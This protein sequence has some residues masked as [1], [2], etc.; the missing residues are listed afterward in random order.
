MLTPTIEDV[1]TTCPSPCSIIRGTNARIPWITP[2]RFTPSTQA[3]SSVR[4]FHERPKVLT[5]AL[6]HSTCTAPKR[7]KEASASAWTEASS[8]TS[9]GTAS[10]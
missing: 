4:N 6:L 7:S 1:F 2:Q 5:P 3:Q 9:V 8:E 10:V